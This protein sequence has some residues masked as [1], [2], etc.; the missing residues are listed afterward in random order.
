MSSSTPHT[1]FLASQPAWYDGLSKNRGLPQQSLIVA[2]SSLSTLSTNHCSHLCALA[3]DCKATC[4][5]H[6]SNNN[7]SPPLQLSRTCLAARGAGGVGCGKVP[8]SNT[9]CIGNQYVCLSTACACCHTA[10]HMT[11]RCSNHV[12]NSLT[13]MHHHPG[14]THAAE[15][16]EQLAVYD[17]TALA[18]GW[19]LGSGSNSVTH[20]LA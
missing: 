9:R 8:T 4:R 1:V 2:D 6:N 14:C 17:G 20:G 11:F 12:T 16:L 18:T 13:D 7:N 15:Q 19:C 3:T 10:S 5:Y